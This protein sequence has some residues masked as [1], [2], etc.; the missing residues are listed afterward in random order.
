MFTLRNTLI[1]LLF[2]IAILFTAWS[3][4][5]ST[6]KNLILLPT[7]HNQPD[8][9]ME[10]VVAT[11]LNKEGH[12][13]LKVATPKM[14]HYFNGDTTEILHPDVTIYRNS[15]Q[16][17]TVHSQFARAKG[18]TNEILFWNHVVVHHPEDT[19]NP[20]TTMQTTTLT[21]FPDE[22]IARTNQPVLIEQPGT[23][24]H[25]VGMIANLN[26]GTVKLLSFAQGEYEP[27]S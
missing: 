22:Q 4:L 24:V 1:T 8:G 2:S 6:H 27:K 10:T 14:V 21:V 5:I 9:F 20:L 17:W 3:I 19:I 7:D 13:T 23:I 18:G 25:A 16:P 26:D 15:P 11:I 12:P